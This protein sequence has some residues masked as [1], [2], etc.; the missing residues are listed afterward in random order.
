MKDSLSKYFNNDLSKEELKGRY[1]SLSFDDIALIDEKVDK[2]HFERVKEK[3]A[4]LE[5]FD[6]K[7]LL[8]QNKLQRILEAIKNNDSW[9]NENPQAH[10]SSEWDAHL[11]RAR[12]L[13]EEKK[14]ILTKQIP[15]ADTKISSIIVKIE[16][17][18]KF[19]DNYKWQDRY[20]LIVKA[21]EREEQQKLKDLS[22]KVEKEIKARQARDFEREKAHNNLLKSLGV[23]EAPYHQQIEAL[24]I[25]H[26][27]KDIEQ[28]CET[29]HIKSL[30]H[31]TPI[32]NITSIIEQGLLSRRHLEKNKISFTPTDQFRMDGWLDC[33]SVS[34]SWPNYKMFCQ[35]RDENITAKGWAILQLHPSILWELPCKYYATNA[36]SKSSAFNNDYHS[37]PWTLRRMFEFEEHRINIPLN[38][39]TDPQA[40]VMVTKHIPTSYI[41]GILVEDAKDLTFI[42]QQT[43]FPTEIYPNIFSYRRD[44][45]HWKGFKLN[46]IHDDII[47][48][49][50]A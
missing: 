25:Y 18:E 2:L 9:F 36:A 14:N 7:K 47:A 48:E 23:D 5:Q 12:S 13:S 28:F 15:N 22:Q 1:F 27:M 20:P 32:E 19:E 4:L 39:T 17:I 31:F 50:L 24:K 6:N 42:R 8:L 11:Q 33:I 21:I 46:L 41:K 45:E 3:Y 37:S 43:D 30:V 29:Q 40:E 26:R 44:Y 38:Y 10:N 34:I 16:E 35:K 49:I